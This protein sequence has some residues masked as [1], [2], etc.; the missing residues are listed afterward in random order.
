MPQVLYWGRA[1]VVLIL[2]VYFNLIMSNVVSL[3]QHWYVET[4]RNGTALEPLYDSLFMDWVGQTGVSLPT[5][6]TLRDMVDVCTWSW[7]IVTLIIWGAFSRKPL[8]AARALSAQILFIPLFTLSQLLTIVPDATPNCLTLFQI[9]TD[10]SIAWIFWRYPLRSC[11]NML[12]SSDIAQLVVFTSIAYDMVPEYKQKFRKL[13]WFVGNCWIL[14]TAGFAFSAKYQYSM[15][16]LSTIIVVKLAMSHPSL[17]SFAQYCFVNGG[18][19]FDR[20]PCNE[21]VP[22]TI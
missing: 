2:V 6:L 16:V 12:W 4:F 14:V 17:E 10:D 9:P 15:D 22:V 20:V 7:V 1:I 3:R 13:V 21:L 19:Y 18:E 8:L 11:G 5:M